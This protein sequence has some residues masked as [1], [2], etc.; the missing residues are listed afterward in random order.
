[1]RVRIHGDWDA[2][3]TSLI[4]NESPK[5]IKDIGEGTVDFLRGVVSSGGRLGKTLYNEFGERFD[6]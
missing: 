4:S 6:P 1:M 3:P 5:G 2:T